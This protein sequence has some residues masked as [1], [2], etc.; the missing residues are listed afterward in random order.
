VIRSGEVRIK[1]AASGVN[2]SD[3]NRRR[4][5]GYAPET[6]RVIPNSDGAG[7]AEY[8]AVQ[9]TRGKDMPWVDF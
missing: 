1:L 6:P 9:C 5:A 7:V 3:C 8:V 2:P 4:G